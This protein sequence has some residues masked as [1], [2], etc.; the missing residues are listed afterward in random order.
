MRRL[1]TFS[2]LSLYCTFCCA[3]G[4][5]LAACTGP[6]ARDRVDWDHGARHGRVLALLAPQAAAREAQECLGNAPLPAGVQF[7]K[8]RYR[9]TRLHHDVVA[10][11]PAGLAVGPGDEV[12]LWP[13]DCGA[14]RMARIERV[15][16]P[17]PAQP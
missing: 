13:E 10:L 2:I 14:G 1:S 8:L 11:A 15:L 4:A 6:L 3:L 17:L 16:P 7:V 12:E 9:R 5:L